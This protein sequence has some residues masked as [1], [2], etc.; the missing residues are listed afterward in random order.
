MGVNAGTGDAGHERPRAQQGIKLR[1]RWVSSTGYSLVELAVVVAI[2]GVVSAIA[3]PSFA[4]LLTETRVGDASSDL[5]SAVI[6]TR[7]EALKRRHRIILCPSDDKQ[8]CSDKV[9]WSPGW[10]MFED[11]NDNGRRE[12]EDRFEGFWKSLGMSVDWRLRYSTI[13]PAARRVSQWSFIDLYRKGLVYRAQAPNP[14]CVDCQTAIAQAEM[15]DAERETT[16]YTLAF[17]LADQPPTTNDQRPPDA[18]PALIE[19]ATTRPELLPA[20]VAV[21]VHPDDQRFASLVG[22]EALALCLCK[23]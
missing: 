9:E 15:D 1:R 11:S 23:K 8:D 2:V 21:F 16:F 3:V 7:S 12:V 6:Q 10:I 18:A 17:G 20:C 13:D 4:R 22:R 5:F 14:W 19:I